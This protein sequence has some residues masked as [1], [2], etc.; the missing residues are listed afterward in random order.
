MMMESNE[1]NLAEKYLIGMLQCFCIGYYFCYG[2][3]TLYKK[4]N[5]IWYIKR[6]PAGIHIL[7][8]L[9]SDI[10]V[11]AITLDKQ[12]DRHTDRHGNIHKDTG[13]HR[14]T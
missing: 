7:A 10:H 5:N 3:I 2:F 8:C 4:T 12:T 9:Y 14:D 1:M 11:H 13:L 6:L